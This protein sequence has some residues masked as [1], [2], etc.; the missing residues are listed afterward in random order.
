MTDAGGVGKA[1]LLLS[2][3]IVQTEYIAA[4][5]S[6]LPVHVSSTSSCVMDLEPPGNR[7]LELR[8]FAA[9]DDRKGNG[10]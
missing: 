7:G 8:G 2:A 3:V 5:I 10:V 9:R 6:L 4:G 1:P